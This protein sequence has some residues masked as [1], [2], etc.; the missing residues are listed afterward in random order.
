MWLDLV[1]HTEVHYTYWRQNPRLYSHQSE[2]GLT[3]SAYLQAA[4][5]SEPKPAALGV[6]KQSPIQIATIQARCSLTQVFV[7][8]LVFPI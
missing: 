7:C 3:L 6:R 8:E 4:L 2:P 1:F 5:V